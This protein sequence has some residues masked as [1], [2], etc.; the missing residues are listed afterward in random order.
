MDRERERERRDGWYILPCV[1]LRVVVRLSGPC[2]GSVRTPRPSS[3]PPGTANPHEE[4]SYYYYDYY[5]YYY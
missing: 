1:L 4:Y 3:S 5:Y 2:P